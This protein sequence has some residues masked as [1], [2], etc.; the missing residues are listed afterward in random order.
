[1]M[2]VESEVSVDDVGGV[3]E[4]N[5]MEELSFCCCIVWYSMMAVMIG[6]IFNDALED[7]S[8]FKCHS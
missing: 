1:M 7:R 3:V 5:V 4:E 6:F 8:S 2:W